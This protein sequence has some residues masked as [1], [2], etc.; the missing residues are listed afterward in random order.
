[1]IDINQDALDRALQTIGKNMDR[2]VGKASY[3]QPKEK[4]EFPL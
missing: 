1:M 2:A 3:F 4:N